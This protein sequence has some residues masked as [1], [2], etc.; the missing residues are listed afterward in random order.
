MS[1]AATFDLPAAGGAPAAPPAPRLEE[2]TTAKGETTIVPGVIAKIASRAARDV[3][4]VG[5]VS[6]SGLR[7]L[8][9]RSDG[10]SASPAG[11]RTALDLHV[12]VTWPQSIPRVTEHVRAAVKARVQELTGYEVTDI[13]I[14]VDSLPAPA[15]SER[16]R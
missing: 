2:L 16:V 13:D 8:F 5:L 12:A 3:D 1:G 6:N 14:T 10:T 15:S 9:S 11:H 4:G 7:S